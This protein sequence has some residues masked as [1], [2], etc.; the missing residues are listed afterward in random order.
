MAERKKIL[1]LVDAYYPDC[2]ANLI[3]VD[4]LIK[5]FKKDYE[6]DFL[7]F[8]HDLCTPLISQNDNG[9]IIRVSTRKTRFLKKHYKLFKAQRWME[10]N[11]ILRKT[12]SF[13]HIIADH[14]SR[15]NHDY[16]MNEI[17]ESLSKTGKNYDIIISV[18]QP[19]CL[20]QIANNLL[21]KYSGAKWY[22]IFL[23]P[24]VYNYCLPESKAE[25][26]KK[27]VC[28]CLEKATKVFMVKGIK[29]ENDR[30][31]FNP[32][33]HKKVVEICLPN[34]KDYTSN[35]LPNKSEAISL[36]YAGIFYKHIRNPKEMFK[37]LDEIGDG[38][39]FNLMSKSCN[40]IINRFVK[41]AKNLKINNLGYLQREECL[42]VLSSS[43]ILIN[44]GNTMPNQTPSKVFE[45]I[46]M[47]KPIINFYFNDNDTS[48]FYFK[49]YPLCFNINV[50]S[51][52]QKDIDEL[53]DFC[54]KSKNKFLTYE[55]ATKNLIENR[56]EV[57][58][59][60]FF[61]EVT[62]D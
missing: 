20:H 4:A 37:I 13:T 7:A 2:S 40:K 49:K 16:D 58:C 3:C 61:D 60:K 11:T 29:E 27:E 24:Q 18:C 28:D 17:Y 15:K 50:N 52:S 38:F 51:Y 23:D 34:L 54:L 35:C 41:K 62:K 26:R 5:N 59:K 39:E 32:E 33:Y 8:A 53:R 56:S 22:P 1:C 46:G 45:Y 10:L 36:A 14:L 48:L 6:I 25:L 30:R 43:D 47:G 42:K 44:L 31:G 57:V 19:F 55:D 9:T 21:K 12:V